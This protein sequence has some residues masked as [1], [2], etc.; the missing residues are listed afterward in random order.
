MIHP[1]LHAE[2]ADA[3]PLAPLEAGTNLLLAG[4]L[5]PALLRLAVPAVGT[6][7]LQILFNVVDTFWVGRTLGAAALAGVS[8]AGYAL[9]LTVS[10]GELVSAGLTAS[11]SR[12]H[13]ERNPRAAARASGTALWLAVLLGALV[14]LVG[15]T[16]SA[17][18][19]HAMG[20]S[21]EVTRL[22]RSFLDVQ[23]AGA[24]LVYGYF[25]VDASFRAAGDTRTPFLLLASSVGLNLVL[26]PMMI[27]GWG[28]FPALGVHGAA[29]ATILT[30]G[31]ALVAGLEL[32]RRRK[33]IR[34]A[35]EPRT[36]GSMLRI[37][38][39]TMLAGSL[40]SAIYMV[41]VRVVQPFGT[42]ALAAL[43]IGHKVE[44]VSYMTLVGI[45]LAAETVVGQNLGA[46]QP[47]RARAGGW[48]ATGLG[49]VV[50]L[51]VT[52][53]FVLVPD[54]LAGIFTHDATVI[55]AAAGYIRAVGTVQIVMAFEVVLE[56][57]MSGAGYTFYPMVW[58]VTLS[59]L[60]IPA[61]IWA[62]P[63]F[64]LQGVWWVLAITMLL[65]GVALT[66]LWIRGSWSSARA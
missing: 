32:L 10:L 49:A 38:L 21:A 28:P 35:F 12:R 24:V 3:G 63:R 30:R 16:G 47:V 18:L 62:A 61:A 11:A 27:L 43:G 57:A 4:P 54:F 58:I 23:L 60:R 48:I 19:F 44:G 55:Q 52:I 14:A 50:G 31:G 22:G 5:R 41:L 53:P 17:A 66:V 45:G 20:T 40:F 1:G 51:A 6:T 36:A 8:T 29:L 7:L 39:P 2:A 33:G 42:P 34:L 59:G 56:A 15:L 64:G 37:G 46:R 26:D 13:G 9:W 25:V 65:R